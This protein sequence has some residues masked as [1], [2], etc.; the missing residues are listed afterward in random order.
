M[1]LPNYIVNGVPVYTVS[2]PDYVS[3][4]KPDYD[5]I[6]SMINEALAACFGRNVRVIRG[7]SKDSHPGKSVD[8]LV[9]IISKNGTDRVEEGVPGRGYG[10][11]V[12]DFF[13]AGF[14]LASSGGMNKWVRK[15]YEGAVKH[16]VRPSRADLFMVYDPEKVAVVPYEKH[17]RVLTDA[18]R[19]KDPEKKLEALLGILKIGGAE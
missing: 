13:A 9:D 7:I 5:R 12:C 19:F 6:G 18:Y 16:K 15:F 8:E 17:G 14:D 4:S 1:S 3:D 11:V 2:I 10:R